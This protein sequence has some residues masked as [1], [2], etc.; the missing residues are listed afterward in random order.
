[1]L[2]KVSTLIKIQLE[3]ALNNPYNAPTA[4]LTAP[5]SSTGTYQPRI[6]ALSG[7][8]G[9]LRYFAYGMLWSGILLIPYFI[10]MAV[11]GPLALSVGWAKYAWMAPVYVGSVILATRR[12]ADLGHSPWFAALMLVPYVNVIPS[13]YFLFKAGDEEANEYGPPPC[14]NTRGVAA[15][16]WTLP[17]VMMV[18]ILAAIAIPAYQ[19]YV[20][21]AQSAHSPSSKL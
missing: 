11:Q 2:Y 14:P 4:D 6:F 19:A 12:L 9:R 18:G 8:L 1:M 10:A 7:R 20:H 5:E 16:A 17:V 13:L 21:R 15:A 3:F